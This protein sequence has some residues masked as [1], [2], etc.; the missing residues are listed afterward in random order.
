MKRVAQPEERA[1]LMT[2]LRGNRG[3][4]QVDLFQWNYEWLDNNRW[5][6][7]AEQL[8]TA[9]ALYPANQWAV[10]D[11]RVDKVGPEWMK[12][13]WPPR[14]MVQTYGSLGSLQPW[15]GNIVAKEP[16]GPSSG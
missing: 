13:G 8:S 5:K 11:G 6:S 16:L 3:L 15:V 14:I 1:G 2:G 12:A 10:C 7:K 9:P 4:C